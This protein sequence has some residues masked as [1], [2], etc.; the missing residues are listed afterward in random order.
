[1]RCSPHQLPSF[2][3]L[4]YSC[5]LNLTLVQLGDLQL[6]HNPSI[7]ASKHS[8][9]GPCVHEVSHTPPAYLLPPVETAV[10]Y[11]S[12]CCTTTEDRIW[13]LG[14]GSVSYLVVWR[15]CQRYRLV[16]SEGEYTRLVPV[17]SMRCSCAPHRAVQQGDC[18]VC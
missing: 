1:M 11:S 18:H 8:S 3:I 12:V 9:P 15:V 2:S 10:Q 13:Q 17:G 14:T 5:P 7:S 16:S 4:E 6:R